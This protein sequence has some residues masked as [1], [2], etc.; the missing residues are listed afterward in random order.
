M[1]SGGVSMLLLC[2]GGPDGTGG[3]GMGVSR[4]V[5]GESVFNGVARVSCGI[6]SGGDAAVSVLLMV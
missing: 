1:V 2:R 4:C 6:W 5:G 3:D